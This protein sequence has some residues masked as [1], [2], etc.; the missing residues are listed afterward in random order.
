M[1]RIVPALLVVLASAALLWRCGSSSPAPAASTATVNGVVFYDQNGNGSIDANEP[2]R[3]PS[4]VVQAGSL[5][6]TSQP[7]GTFSMAGVPYGLTSIGVNLQTLPPYYQMTTPLSVQVPQ[8]TGNSIPV[9]ITLP[10]GTNLPNVYMGFGDSITVGDGSTD[11]TGYRGPLQDQLVAYF[12]AATIVDQGIEATR[13]KEGA[14]RILSS[15]QQTTPAFVVIVYGTNDWNEQACR[16]AP[17]CYT[18]TN[19]KFMVDTAKSFNSFP[20]LSTILPV[21]VGYDERVPPEREVWVENQNVL[22]RQLAAQEGVVLVDLEAAF[23]DAFAQNGGDYQAFYYDHVHPSDKGYAVMAQTLFN[24]ITKRVS[25]T[26]S[27]SPSPP[28]FP[29]PGASP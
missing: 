28:P 12:G 29:Y 26:A 7:G 9:P 15:L 6:A 19:L 5:F 24:A 16:D 14:T 23:L 1:K 18:I 21:N 11:G 3:F 2:V 20:F 17:P 10:I 22:I 25:P 4:A 13:T 8:E 27:P